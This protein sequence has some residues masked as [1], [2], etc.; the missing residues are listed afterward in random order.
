[1]SNITSSHQT[2]VVVTPAT[3]KQQ[4]ISRI[5]TL[6]SKAGGQYFKTDSNG[7]SIPMIEIEG[8]EVYGIESRGR[9]VYLMTIDSDEDIQNNQDEA[10]IP[11]N[12]NE[13]YIEQLWV[14][15]LACEPLY[16]S[17]FNDYATFQE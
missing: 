13:F 7:F 12:A 8:L 9:E 2:A 14:V 3:L 6:V 5:N 1:M 10:Y 11:Y 4:I 16:Q 17:K 15:Y